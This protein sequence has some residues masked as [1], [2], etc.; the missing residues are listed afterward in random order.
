MHLGGKILALQLIAGDSVSKK[1]LD[2][3]KK[4]KNNNDREYFSCAA[5][6]KY[7]LLAN[8][9]PK[10]SNFEKMFLPYLAVYFYIGVGGMGAAP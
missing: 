5:L 7:N 2:G 1:I 8:S 6:F 10:L 4:Y 3:F 9:L